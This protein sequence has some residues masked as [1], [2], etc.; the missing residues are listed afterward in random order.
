MA[1]ATSSPRPFGKRE[2]A[3]LADLAATFVPG[4]DAQRVAGIAAEALVRAVD[5]SQLGQ[6]RLVLRLLE[7]RLANLLTARRASGFGAMSVEEREALLLGWAGSPLA[8]QRAAFHAFRKLLTFIAYADPGA[9]GSANPLPIAI[10]YQPDSPPQTQD[11]AHIRTLRVDRSAGSRPDRPIDLEADVIVVGSGAGGGV[12]AAELS[13]A[14]RSALVIEAGPFVDEASMPRGELDAYGRL[15]LNYGL[16][17]TWDGAIT[18][19]AG[20]GFGGGTL[21]NWM[22]CIDVPADV[23]AEWAI[24]HGLDG[25]DGEEWTTDVSAIETEL[26][27]APVR[28]VPAKDQLILRGTAALGWE[29]DRIRRNAVECGDCGACPFGC[30]RGT[31]QSGIRVHLARAN[32]DGARI[33]ERARVT[34]LLL[35]GGRVTGVSGDLLADVPAAAEPSV[36][37]GRPAA[38]PTR[39]FTARAPQVVLAAGALRS[40]AI[41]QASGVRHPGIGRYLRIHPAPVIGAVMAQPVDMWRG[42]MQAVRSVQFSADQPDRRGYVI[43]SAPGH[44]G[45]LALVVPWEGQQEHAAIMARARHFAPLVAV[46]RDGGEGR[47]SLTRA[48]RVRVDYQLDDLGRATL[49]HALVAMANIARAGGADEILAIGL[50]LLR[51]RTEWRDEGN[52]FKAFERQLAERDF[53]PHRGTIASAHQMGTIRIGTDAADHPADEQGRIRADSGGRLIA[54]LYVADT[55]TFPTAIGVNPMIAVM[56]MARRISRTVLA[57][58]APRS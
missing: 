38:A 41:L 13:R 58:G 50:P 29:A 30:R 32:A 26:G 4:A 44:L 7:V 40:P 14:G 34:R 47:T 57:E 11:L 49:R 3:T 33:L 28:V 54:G 46:T 9:P 42:T 21:V 18:I 51:H 52:R 19:L 43:E 17:S 39:P 24:E 55:S 27:V 8:Q 53:R 12:M 2:V 1:A 5:P 6:L 48:G 36:G 35:D 37:S 31:K 56:A 15:Y 10:G 20:S 45:L 23:R 25:L 22:T 16:L